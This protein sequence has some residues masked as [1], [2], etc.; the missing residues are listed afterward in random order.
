MLKGKLNNGLQEALEHGN[1]AGCVYQAMYPK[2]HN[3]WQRPFEKWYSEENLQSPK[4]VTG[5]SKR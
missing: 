3:K 1:T 4:A 5:G 2:T